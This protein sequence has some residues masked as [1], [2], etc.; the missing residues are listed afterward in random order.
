LNRGNPQKIFRMDSIPH[1]HTRGNSETF[2]LYTLPPFLLCKT[3]L[4]LNNKVEKGSESWRIKKH[5]AV[6]GLTADTAYEYVIIGSIDSTSFTFV[7]KLPLLL[8]MAFVLLAYMGF[9]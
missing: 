6:F 8:D 1:I 9:Y 7:R 4:H 5:L 2:S 3:N